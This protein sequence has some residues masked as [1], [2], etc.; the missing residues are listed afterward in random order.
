MGRDKSRIDIE[1]T[2]YN[3]KLA[4]SRPDLRGD[5][6]F[7]GVFERPELEIDSDDPDFQ[8][9]NAKNSLKR[10]RKLQRDSDEEDNKVMVKSVDS[11]EDEGSSDDGTWRKNIKAV[12]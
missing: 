9:R 4:E 8:M 6:R 10:I 12:H 5:D 7:G 11:S 2:K 1:P 3:K